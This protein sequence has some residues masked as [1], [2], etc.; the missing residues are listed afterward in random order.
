MSAALHRTLRVASLGVL[1][2]A[3]SAAG[4]QELSL[5]RWLS[6]EAGPY[7]AQRLATHPRFKG[8]RI[9]LVALDGEQ[10][11]E[12]PDRL[13]VD[14]QSRLAAVLLDQPG[15]RLA[16]DAGTATGTPLPGDDSFD[17]FADADIAYYL[18]V[19]SVALGGGR[20]QVRLRVLDL[21]ERA[22]V[23]GSSQQWS[24]RL[25]SSHQRSV[26]KPSERAPAGTRTRPFEAGEGDLLAAR[27]ARDVVCE[28]SARRAGDVRVHAPVAQ[29]GQ[30][31]PTLLLS[32]LSR[33]RGIRVVDEPEAADLV[34]ALRTHTIDRSL[35]QLW[36]QLTPPGGEGGAPPVSASVYTRPDAL[37]APEMAQMVAATVAPTVG[38]R[39]VARLAPIAARG[40][41]LAAPRVVTPRHSGLCRTS[42]PWRR[43]AVAA[44]DGGVI[45]DAGCYAVEVSANRSVQLFAVT[46]APDGGL[47][48]LPP[49]HCD[50]TPSRRALPLRGSGLLRFPV[51]TRAGDSTGTL[52]L[53][54][55]AGDAE[56]SAL[57]DRINQLPSAC[58]PVRG[59]GDVDVGRWINETEQWMTAL[60]DD[61]G[62]QAVRVRRA[63]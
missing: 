63:R 45:G 30:P 14:I 32:Y 39:K 9:R 50:R 12:A 17:C 54:A 40:P 27:L 60:G 43:G 10:V 56:A 28:L 22:F 24:G 33:Q 34:L 7:Y 62:W 25:S 23:S 48:H 61:A 35:T 20:H 42:D 26:G 59:A 51:A 4:A 53:L 16:W 31:D 57:A 38:E 15:V 2:A 37:A 49:V 6:A 8:E 29:A 58:A 19:D 18:G 55:A 11:V 36:V 41:L 47:M 3:A 52:I 46:A 13:T 1:L 5:E 21:A 44:P